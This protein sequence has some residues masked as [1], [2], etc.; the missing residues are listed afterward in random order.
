MKAWQLQGLEKKTMAS[1]RVVG[2]SGVSGVSIPII[3]IRD[4]DFPGDSWVFY[5]FFKT[6]QAYNPSAERR[7]T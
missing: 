7:T 2:V 4:M 3:Y 5:G 6:K 1:W